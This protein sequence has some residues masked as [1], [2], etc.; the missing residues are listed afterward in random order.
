MAKTFSTGS[1]GVYPNTRVKGFDIVMSNLNKAIM[2]IEG[3]TLKG[4]L[5]AAALIRRETERTPPLT[6]V[7]TGNLRASWFVV[8]SQKQRI[9]KARVSSDVHGKLIQTGKFKGKK[10][11]EMAANHTSTIQQAKAILHSRK[12]DIVVMMGYTANY[13]LFVHESV[14]KQFHR[15]GS[16]PKW[17]ETAIKNNSSSILNIIENTSKPML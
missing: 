1:L 10:K 9:G 4:L 16:G 11:A 15:E 12:E 2:N 6:P 3:G 8:S 13:A 17:F 14:D 5:L 7:D